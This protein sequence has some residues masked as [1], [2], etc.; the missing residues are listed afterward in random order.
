MSPRG[1]PGGLAGDQDS[2]TQFSR[3]AE[4]YRSSPTHSDPVSL[5]RFIALAELRPNHV[6]LDVATGAGH[7]ALAAAAHV[8]RVV[9][10]DI[11]PAM[12]DQARRLAAEREIRNVEFVEGNAEALPFAAQSFDRVLV[13]SAPHHFGQLIPALAEAYRVLRPGG[14]FAVSDCSPP[15]V[16]RDWL[17]VVEVGRDPSHVRSRA[18]E[19]WRAL[20][21]AI[22]FTV[23]HAERIEQ[24]KDI[25]EWF[26]IARVSEAT[27][28]QLLDYYEGAPQAVRGQLLPQ[29]RE[30]RFYHRYWHALIRARRPLDAGV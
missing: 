13:R 1:E 3:V 27:R 28:R 29:W 21:Q 2:R 14:A 5:A 8:R 12:L 19:E 16:V 20:L 6:V 11:T 24:E 15:P 23:E 26:E 4:A 30:G 25:L 17:A 22:G 9:G 18:L 7:S 10:L